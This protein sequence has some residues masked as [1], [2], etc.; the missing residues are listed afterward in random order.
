[1][2]FLQELAD[3]VTN[4][5]TTVFE[6]IDYLLQSSQVIRNLRIFTFPG[7]TK[8][9]TKLSTVLVSTQPLPRTR[10]AVQ[11]N[12]PLQLGDEIADF[13]LALFVRCLRCGRGD[14][15][16]EA[17]II[18]KRIE[19]RIELEQ[20]RSERRRGESAKVGCRE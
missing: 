9:D 18:P 1:M 2:A 6:P 20:R 14:E 5:Q 7:D 17:R 3:V 4:V 19:H 11:N 10:A 13:R 12:L 15:F 8:G 16:L